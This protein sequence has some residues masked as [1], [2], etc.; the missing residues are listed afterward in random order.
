MTE[1]G[2]ANWGQFGMPVASN[3]ETGYLWSPLELEVI[4]QNVID[5][6]LKKVD[7]A[8]ENIK[9]QRNGNT[10]RN[11]ITFISEVESRVRWKSPNEYNKELGKLL[12][13]FKE[14]K[15]FVASEISNNLDLAL[16]DE[17]KDFGK[18][19]FL[20]EGIIEELLFVMKDETL[21]W[22]KEKME[23]GIIFGISTNGWVNFKHQERVSPVP[24]ELKTYWAN[25]KW[26]IPELL[27]VIDLLNLMFL[28]VEL[29]SMRSVVINMHNLWVN[30]A[31]ILRKGNKFAQNN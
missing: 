11:V 28:K 21:K 30:V 1:W 15:K 4:E 18:K 24:D 16:R 7:D 5:E 27:L 2:M 10:H 19:F 14:W 23:T 12:E 8:I 22:V 3:Q 25:E 31:D 9:K 13:K 26:R 29:L 17:K 20:S 6:A